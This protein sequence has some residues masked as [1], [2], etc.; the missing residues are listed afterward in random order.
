MSRSMI[1]LSVE[2]LPRSALLVFPPGC[3]LCRPPLFASGLLRLRTDALAR[4]PLSPKG[5]QHPDVPRM[6]AHP[7]VRLGQILQPGQPRAHHSQK[8][9]QDGGRKHRKCRACVQLPRRLK[10][11]HIVRQA[12]GL[13]LA[14]AE[15][16]E[17][18]FA[19]WARTGAASSRSL[20]VRGSRRAPMGHRMQYLY[21]GTPVGDG[22]A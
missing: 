12:R 8:A 6:C 1:S 2:L 20:G 17:A 4:E 18:A 13:D 3:L 5:T 16:L 10:I 11:Q 15:L 19:E 22:T 7:L 14:V 21:W 9:A